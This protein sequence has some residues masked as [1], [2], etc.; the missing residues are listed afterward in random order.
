MDIKVKDTTER[1][2]DRRGKRNTTTDSPDVPITE[3][4][5][6]GY[7]RVLFD[8]KAESNAEIDLKKD[9]IIRLLSK[10]PNGSDWWGGQKVIPDES[11]GRCEAGYF[12]KDFVESTVAPNDPRFETI[13]QT[14]TTTISTLKQSEIDLKHKIETLEIEVGMLKRELAEKKRTPP[15]ET[16]PTTSDATTARTTSTPSFWGFPL[17]MLNG[18]IRVQKWRAFLLALLYAIVHL[19]PSLRTKRL[20]YRG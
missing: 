9:E 2:N 4:E 15:Q 11:T 3:E 18:T 17:H 7:V 20:S 5:T 19:V 16:R 13:R 10:G 6:L 12:P 1:L 8:F 14:M